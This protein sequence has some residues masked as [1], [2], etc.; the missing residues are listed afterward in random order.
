MIRAVSSGDGDESQRSDREANTEYPIWEATM[1][2]AVRVNRGNNN[3]IDG[4]MSGYKWDPATGPVTFSSPN[5]ANDYTSSERRE[6]FVDPKTGKVKF[7]QIPP[8]QMQ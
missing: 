6:L 2:N 8:E 1:A 3:Y 7:A 4:L 5:S